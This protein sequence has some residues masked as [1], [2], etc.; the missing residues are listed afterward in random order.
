MRVLSSAF[1]QSAVNSRCHMRAMASGESHAANGAAESP[2]RANSCSGRASDGLTCTNW[3]HG[4][5]A[6]DQCCGADRATDLL[7]SLAIRQF[8]DSPVHV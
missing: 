2:I 8:A 3:D 1:R 5:G 4:R 7:V 6:V